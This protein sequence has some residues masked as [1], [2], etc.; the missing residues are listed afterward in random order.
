MVAIPVL[1]TVAASGFAQLVAWIFDDPD[2]GY[3]SGP[4][5]TSIDD[6]NPEELAEYEKT[7]MDSFSQEHY[8]RIAAELGNE[9]AD[10]FLERFYT[11]CDGGVKWPDAARILLPE[12]RTFPGMQKNWAQYSDHSRYRYRHSG[13]GWEVDYPESKRKEINIDEIKLELNR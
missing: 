5:S 9:K 8:E 11:L 4:R 13:D 3:A 10:E 2:R 7:I 1:L 6:M 12:Y